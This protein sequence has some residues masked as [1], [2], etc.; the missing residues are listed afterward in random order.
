MSMDEET[1]VP[2]IQQT[3]TIP[4][5]ADLALRMGKYN[6]NN[7]FNVVVSFTFLNAHISFKLTSRGQVLKF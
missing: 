2:Y 6:I 4:N 7:L 3:N 1:V 5:N